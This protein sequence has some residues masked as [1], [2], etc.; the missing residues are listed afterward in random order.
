MTKNKKGREFPFT[1]D[2]RGLVEGQRTHTDAVQKERGAII[3]HVFHRQGKPIR[4]LY[5]TW[6]S[7]CAAAGCPG[8]IPHDFRR[9][10]V[11]NLVR[12][13]IPERV[14]MT[15]TG[16]KTREVFERYN[17]V[18]DGDLDDAARLLDEATVTVTVTKTATQ[19]PERGRV[20]ARE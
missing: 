11:G 10:D 4:W 6:R 13:C 3:P 5:G 12:A 7:A 20:R 14:A 2:L 18:S 17:I 9:T 16:H 8:R 1:R 19:P 15:M